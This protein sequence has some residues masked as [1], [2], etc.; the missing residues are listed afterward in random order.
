MKDHFSLRYPPSLGA[1]F[2]EDTLPWAESLTLTMPDF[3]ASY[4]LH[5]S[6]FEALW[7]QPT[8][9]EATAVL[10]W[11]SYWTNGRVPYK[12]PEDSFEHG[13][14]VMPILLI[15]IHNIAQLLWRDTPRQADPYP[16]IIMWAKSTMVTLEARESILTA[17][18]LEPHTSDEKLLY[19][20][21]DNLYHTQIV[22]LDDERIVEILHGGTVS[23]LCYSWR[24]EHLTIP[25]P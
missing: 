10:R 14:N 3:L 13:E 22:G 23:L 1:A 8:Y 17:A 2:F 25:Q 18:L 7:L 5:D 6:L 15:R 4:T 20:L 21:E 12:E 16:D 24:G 11:D 9:A 19:L